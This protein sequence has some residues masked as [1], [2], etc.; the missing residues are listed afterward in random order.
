MRRLPDK[1]IVRLRGT[2]QS[3]LRLVSR[4]PKAPALTVASATLGGIVG[5]SA[6]ALLVVA[7]TEMIK[8]VLGA[9]SRQATWV[10]IVLPLVGLSLS[11]LVLYGLGLSSETRNSQRPRWAAAWRTFPPGAVRSDLSGD[12]VEFAGKE[13][14]FPWRLAPI[15]LLAI[16]ATVGLGAAMGTEKPAA[17]LG[18]A[19]G[20]ALG[21]RLW[22][23]LARP[24]AV[25]GG[26]AGVAVLM[27]IP[28]V[29]TAFILELERRHHAPL[30]LERVTAALVGGFVGWLWHIALNVDLIR[31]VVPREPPHSF[32]QAL[33][34]ALL[35]GLLSGSITSIAGEA[36]YRAKFWHARP[37]VRLALGGLGLGTAAVILSMIASPAAA[38]GPGGGAITWVEN[39]RAPALTMLAVCL[40]RA[41]ATTA[42][43]AVGGCG[44]LF[45]PFLTIGDLGGRVFA[46]SLQVPS[47]LAGA[48]GAA[49]GISGGYHLPFT[50]IALVLGQGGPPLAVL[51]CLATVLVATYAGTG[52]AYLLDLIVGRSHHPVVSDSY[53]F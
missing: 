40:L 9:V 10:L 16:Y 19:T 34:T 44:G 48:A 39:A 15:R 29:G 2:V 49:S 23:R 1:W 43:S 12:V 46:P 26:A 7:V 8:V 45:V 38:I 21:S 27:G 6:A 52:A 11:V 5:G 25:A 42:S 28:L 33:I 24:L 47:D 22:R 50:A 37:I 36:I 13:E 53:T 4:D 41:V 20:A 30:N 32:H 31:L 35:I 51:T 17:Y 14:H 3:R 18:V